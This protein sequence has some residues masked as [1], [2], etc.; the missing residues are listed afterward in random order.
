MPVEEDMEVRSEIQEIALTHRRRY[1]S[2]SFAKTHI[3]AEP[4]HF[5]RK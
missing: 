4:L 3:H 5:P 1:G 2:L